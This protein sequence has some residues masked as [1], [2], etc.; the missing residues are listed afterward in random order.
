MKKCIFILMLLLALM[1]ITAY[2]SDS[3]NI[4]E[5]QQS[6]IN[7]LYDYISNMQD[8]NELLR[9]ISPKEF[10]ESY[11]KNGQ[12]TGEERRLLKAGIAYL[13]REVLASFTIIGQLIIIAI[14]CALLN[15]LQN[16]FSNEKVAHVA[17]FACYGVM[18]ILIARGFYIGVEL[19]QDVI[20]TISNFM[21]AL[22]P[23]LIM[24]LASVGSVSQALIMDPIVMGLCTFGTHL[25][26]TVIIPVVCMSFVLS[27]VN[28]ISSDYNI[29][30]LTNLLKKS[31]LWVQGI[32]LTVFIGL[33]TIRGIAGSS[34][35]IVTTKTA[36]FAVES[37]VP[38]VGKAI[39]DAFATVASYTLLLKNSISL[40]GT[41]ILICIILLPIIKIYALGFMYKLTSALLQPV[42]DKKVSSVID[43]AGGSLMLLGSCIVCVSIMFF[44]VLAMVAATGKGFIMM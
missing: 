41:V 24:L 34:L 7:E 23:V 44:I 19:T 43:S 15:N 17:Y 35:D 20:K 33:L 30:N 27:F 8:E 9:E 21:A 25:Y 28:N 29:D 39:S 31:A 14:V 13:F 3:I 22:M 37:F 10:V 11:M 36:K 2:G 5:E 4:D 40:L 12:D 16:A 38:V 42:T 1:P 32:F 18:I 26:S 6:K